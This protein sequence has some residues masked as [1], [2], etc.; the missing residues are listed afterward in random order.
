MTTSRLSVD[1]YKAG[2]LKGDRVIL[3]RAITLMESSLAEDQRL[4]SEVLD[5]LTPYAGNSL[6][7]GITGSPG[8]GKSTFI[9]A[10]GKMLTGSGK[11]LAVLTI[12]PSSQ[13][14]GGS[15]LGD[16]T[17]MGELS[18]DRHA[19]IRPSP[20]GT[21]LGG[22]AAHTREAI[23]L[24]EA[25]GFHMIVVETVGSGQSEIAVRNMVDFFLLL[26]QPGSGDELQG[27]KKGIVE[28]ADAIAI[29]KADGDHVRTAKMTQSDF[30]HALHLV[31]RKTP[32]WDPKVIT[33]S[34]F[35]QL[36]LK[37][38][39]DTLEEYKKEMSSTGFIQTI[40][41]EQNLSWF[42]EH[43]QRL[44]LNDPKRFRE[45]HQKEQI[46]SA[47]VMSG[48]VSPRIA[49]QHL[50]DA[51]LQAVSNPTGDNDSTKT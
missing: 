15:I 23:V 36:G 6:R 26:V 20:A 7:V 11:K 16:K 27:I 45:I 3:A 18:R 44:L 5:V 12:D 1:E 24:C 17:R 37:E 13:V 4:A 43:F 8:V 9:E 22:V 10:F 35:E 39:S 34:S 51:Y 32:G 30:Q 31:Q 29:T 25:A 48:R 33:C 38:I 42:S 28:M 19:F 41:K 50:L 21:T 47:Q 49:A 2:I 46:L 14:T 40:R